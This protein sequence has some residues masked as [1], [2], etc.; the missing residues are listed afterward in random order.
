MKKSMAVLTFFLALMLLCGCFVGCEVEKDVQ[1]DISE[2][3]EQD[4]KEDLFKDLKIE[5]SFAD[6]KPYHLYFLS[7]GDGTCALK[8][9]TVNPENEQDFVLEI[10]ET[11]PAGDTVTSVDIVQDASAAFGKDPSVQNFPW[12]LSEA[13]Y[14]AICQTAQANNIPDFDYNKMRAYFYEISIEGMDDEADKEQRIDVYPIAKYGKVYVF[15]RNASKTEIA[16]IH[17]YMTE[18]AEWDDAKY[19]KNVDEV[20]AL[21]KQSES[22]EEAE[23]CLTAFRNVSLSQIV[24]ISI[25]KTV[26]KI[27]NVLWANAN[28]LKSVTVAE[29]NPTIKMIYGCLVDTENDTLMLYLREDGNV[30]PQAGIQI[31]DTNAFCHLYMPLP[32]GD[33]NARLDLYIPG[34]VTE[35]RS[36]CFKGITTESEVTLNIHLP[37]SLRKVGKMSDSYL[38]HNN[39]TWQRYS[40]MYHYD[41][42]RQEWETGITFEPSGKEEVYIYLWT[43]DDTYFRKFV[44][45]RK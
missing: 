13:S 1:Q 34:G 27:N 31:V 22:L 2:S 20:M 33:M 40:Y 41:G 26:T 42:T 17:G 29:D 28:N 21:A 38:N 24:G 10:P 19:Q 36:D 12:V 18:Y 7:N 9:V 6:G 35:L 37:A 11:S 5:D 4:A 8:Y 44:F 45:P 15:T 32:E 23:L 39:G 25:P 43:S 3:T 30:P 16:K 14:Q